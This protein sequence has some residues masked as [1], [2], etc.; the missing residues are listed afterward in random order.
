MRSHLQRAGLPAADRMATD[1]RA[2]PRGMCEVPAA[3]PQSHNLGLEFNCLLA[4][5]SGVHTNA[6][7]S[8]CKMVDGEKALSLNKA[9]HQL[10]PDVNAKE[11]TKNAEQ[12]AKDD[13][14]DLGS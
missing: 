2:L 12:Q 1:A 14:K 11:A 7:L 6:D 13:L 3:T 10:K 9:I 8:G 5:V 4:G